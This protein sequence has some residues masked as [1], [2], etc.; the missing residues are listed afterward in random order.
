MRTAVT[1]K[2]ARTEWTAEPEFLGVSAAAQLL[3]VSEASIRRFFTQKKLKRFKVGAR[4]VARRSDVL[5][6]AI[7]EEK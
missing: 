3:G 2:S 4:S 1:A 6:L 7:P 5:A